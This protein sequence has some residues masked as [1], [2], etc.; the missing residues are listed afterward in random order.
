[1]RTICCHYYTEYSFLQH[2]ANYEP[3]LEVKKLPD[4]IAFNKYSELLI[5]SEIESL[6]KQLLNRN[7]RVC[8]Y[9]IGFTEG[10]ILDEINPN[11]QES[12]MTDKFFIED[13]FK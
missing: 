2:L 7:K 6:T 5:N 13:Y 12:Y 11:W 3:S 8:F 9:A 10:L 4:F 1:M